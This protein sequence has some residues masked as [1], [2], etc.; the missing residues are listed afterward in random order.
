VPLVTVTTLTVSSQTETVEQFDLSTVLSIV[1]SMLAVGVIV[2][3]VDYLTPNKRLASLVGIYLGIC[4]GLIGALAMA[5]LID[6]VAQAWELS[7]PEAPNPFIGLAKVVVG[8]VL[9]YLAVSFVLTTKDD[10]R[11]VIPYVEFAKQVRGIRPLAL[12]TS[13]LIDGRIESIVQ[14]GFIDA[15]LIIP[16]FVIEELQR[17]SDSGDRL[18]R[19]RGR[20]GLDVVTKLQNN[21]TIDV[22]IDDIEVPGHT[23]DRMLVELAHTQQMRILTTDYN[24]LKVAKINGVTALNVNDLAAGLK[25]V[26]M[27]GES[28]QVEIVKQGENEGQGVGYMPDGTMIVVENGADRIGDVVG[29]TVTNSLQTSAGRMIFAKL[30]GV[31]HEEP[32]PRDDATRSTV[33]AATSQPRDTDRPK[34]P[35]PARSRR[36]PRR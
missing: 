5:K 24:L 20:R 33:E 4:V 32:R 15:P 30:N 19:M 29:V 11:L 8:I 14:S 10:F 27:P 6:V 13:V 34:R 23:V 1:L 35:S 21:G 16:V 25:T 12:D 18:K 26:V 22:S 2:L 9:C 3:A 28:L 17:L 31:Q 36:N 7:S